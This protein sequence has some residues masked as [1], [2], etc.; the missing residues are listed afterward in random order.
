MSLFNEGERI[1]KESG[2]EKILKEEGERVGLQPRRILPCQRGGKESGAVAQVR[3]IGGG[4]GYYEGEAVFVF[5]EP[6]L[7]ELSVRSAREPVKVT[8][9]VRGDGGWTKRRLEIRQAIRAGIE[10]PAKVFWYE[11]ME[12]EEARYK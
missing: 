6:E 11:G 7:R 10:K 12:D 2:V 8:L 1:L 3:G 4:A 5:V 9:P